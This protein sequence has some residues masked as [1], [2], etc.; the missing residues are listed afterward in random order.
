MP[1]TDQSGQCGQ[2][3]EVGYGAPS[4]PLN[5]PQNGGPGY[6]WQMQWETNTGVAPPGF[7]S[8]AALTLKTNI[9]SVGLIHLPNPFVNS[10]YNLN[11]LTADPLPSAP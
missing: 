4:L 9:V 1:D 11:T 6:Y 10:T 7:I 3:F 2:K 8:G 5:N